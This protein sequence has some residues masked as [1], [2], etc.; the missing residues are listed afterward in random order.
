MEIMRR[1]SQNAFIQGKAVGMPWVSVTLLTSACI[2]VFKEIWIKDVKFMRV[3]TDDGAVF[4]VHFANFPDV[5]AVVDDVV[6]KL[7]PAD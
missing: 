5:L 1:R 4:C 7:I 2:K 3:D 6:V